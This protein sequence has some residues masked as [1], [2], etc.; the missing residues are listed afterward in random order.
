MLIER[1]RAWVKA[2]IPAFICKET[3][4][5]ISRWIQTNIF[6]CPHC[7]QEYRSLK[8]IWDCL[9]QWEPET[10]PT[11]CELAFSNKFREQFP[12]AFKND[13]EIR[14][15]LLHS[16]IGKGALVGGIAVVALVCTLVLNSPEISINK[17][18]MAQSVTNLSQSDSHPKN[19]S[20]PS[21]PEETQAIARVEPEDAAENY[22][23][24]SE[25]M[26]VRAFQVRTVS[27]GESV[28]AASTRT[29]LLPRHAVEINNHPVVGFSA[30]SYS[31]EE[32]AY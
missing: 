7:R 26:D 16:W 22:I 2:R 29:G 4:W 28:T 31:T 17:T 11:E 13:S 32:D 24:P 27:T 3:N 14:A 19:T 30:L 15:S 23:P 5:W 12:S 25:R 8:K 10:P 9:D 20:I 18:E 6:L 1:S 21:A